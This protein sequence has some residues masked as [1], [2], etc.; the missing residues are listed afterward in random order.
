MYLVAVVENVKRQIKN[1]LINNNNII[2][3]NHTYFMKQTFNKLYPKY[4][5]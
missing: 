3:D 4:G 5:T 2:I 1:N